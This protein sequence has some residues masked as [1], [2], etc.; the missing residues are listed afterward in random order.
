MEENDES[1]NSTEQGDARQITNKE[2]V[3]QVIPKVPD[4]ASAAVC[5]KSG[6]PTAG[7]WPAE[8]A[9]SASLSVDQNNYL[10]C[11]SFRPGED[12]TFNVR[13]EQFAALHFLLLDDLGTKVP[14]ERLKDF[15]LSW[16]IETSPGNY[17]GGIIL[18]EPIT[19]V[20]AADRLIKALGVAG[21]NDKG[22]SGVGRWARLPNAIN[23]KE[24]YKDE[25]GHPFKC[26]LDQLHPEKRYSIQKIVDELGLDLYPRKGI[27]T[28]SGDDVFIPEAMEN[29]VITALKARGLYKTPLGSGKHDITCPWVNEH[30][31]ARD[32]GSA[33]FE[34]DDDY[35][36]GGFCCQHSHR[37]QYHIN[38]LLDYLKIPKTE[39]GN[40]PVIRIVPGE[41]HRVV[42]AAERELAKAGR[43]YQAG[44]LIV[45]VST[46]KMTGDPSILPVNLSGLTRQ[47]SS[48][49]NWE[50]N[51]SRMDWSRCDP[52]TR[53]TGILFENR[54]FRYLSPLIGVARQ[55]YFR[56]S[57]NELVM[58]PGYDPKSMMFGV[59]DPSQFSIPD[60]PTI[61][62]AR[63][64]LALLEGLLDEFHYVSA[65]DKAAALSAII[66]AVVRPSLPQAPA[67]HIRAPSYGSGKSYQCELIGAFAGPASNAKVSYPK[68]SEEASKVVLS[69]LLKNP[70]VIEFDDM[71]ADWIPH[72][73]ILRTLTAEQVTERIL[74]YSK[75]A[76]VSTRTL[77]LGSG[78]NVGPV[79]DLLR[80]VLTIHVDP[81]CSTPATIQYKG[82]PVEQVRRER[83]KYVAAVLT[84][85]QAYRKC[86]SPKTEV[87]SIVSFSGAWSDYCRQPLLWLGY[88]DPASSLLEQVKHDPDAE[89]LGR[90]MFEWNRVFGSVPTT[91]RKVV[92]SASWDED[93][94]DALR[95]FPVEEKGSIN[96]S[97]LGWI[98]KKNVNRIVNGFEFKEAEADGRKGWR[99][100]SVTKEM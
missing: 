58:E 30:T 12:G 14:L 63:N 32:S 77:F 93:L 9:D 62:D 55:P 99:V 25:N 74:G 35:P 85:I 3:E 38:E 21:L 13:K 47:L 90:L 49:V 6:A 44:G 83:G 71:D 69:L 73:I 11:S 72:G 51:N 81:R 7:G 52:P 28:K 89:V 33:Y 95:E 18:E 78:N 79:R 37:D 26:R 23:G 27:A 100:V 4:G 56:E 48:I 67:Y 8:R 41:L 64:S 92:S 94:L 80:R 88:P 31:D 16:V 45:T 19:D 43:H 68:N 5:S 50:K 91:V 98:L 20:E 15:E 59:F 39:A 34:P 60:D 22:A 84:I 17:Q 61:D 66:T 87:E 86:G 75:T 97:K 40:K 10:S 70:A 24:K 29:P 96:R 2:F 42:D 76:T 1:K 57:D 46:D 65:V 54:N 53:H 36:N 82:D